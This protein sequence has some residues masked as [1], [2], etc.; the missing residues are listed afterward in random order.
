MSAY[1]YVAAVFAD[2]QLPITATNS[3]GRARYPHMDSLDIY[4]PNPGSPEAMP[5]GC[6]CPPIQ[7]DPRFTVD[8]RCPLHGFETVRPLFQVGPLDQMATTS[9]QA[10]RFSH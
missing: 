3:S 8:E 5:L 10:T 2:E 6:T 1:S 9:N 7:H 4:E